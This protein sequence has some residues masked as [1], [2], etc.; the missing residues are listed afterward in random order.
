MQQIGLRT[1]FRCA[2]GERHELS[3]P[4]HLPGGAVS[5][6]AT[7]QLRDTARETGRLD[8]IFK[9]MRRCTSRRSRILASI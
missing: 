8:H 2:R 5:G 6:G 3:L 4:A 7:G 1:A 9:S